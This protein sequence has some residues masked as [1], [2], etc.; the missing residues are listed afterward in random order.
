MP[1]DKKKPRKGMLR[2]VERDKY[3]DGQLNENDEGALRFSVGVE[4]GKVILAFGKA[5][6]WVGLDANG[7]MQLAELLTKKAREVSS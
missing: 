3:P 4:N 2:L 5:V 7:A 6:K 1:N